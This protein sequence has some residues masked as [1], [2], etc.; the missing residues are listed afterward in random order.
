MFAPNAISVTD[1][2]LCVKTSV[3]PIE[4]FVELFSEYQQSNPATIAAGFPICFVFA[5]MT[6]LAVTMLSPEKESRSC[7]TAATT[8]TCGDSL[9]DEF[10]CTCFRC[11]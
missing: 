8:A 9:R 5:V 1:Y 6:P 4:Y 7:C 2:R 11:R 10:D 3:T